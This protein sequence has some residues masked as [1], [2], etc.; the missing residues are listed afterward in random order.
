MKK[1]LTFSVLALF[2]GALGLTSCG[3]DNTTDDGALPAP[4]N[5]KAEN[6]TDVSATLSWDAVEGA[7][8]YNV[9]I[10]NKTYP[11]ASGTTIPATGLTAETAYEWKVVAVNAAGGT[12]AEAKATFTTTAPL[13]K[14]PAPTALAVTEGSIT[15]TGATFTWTGAEGATG[16]NIR[17]NGGTPTAVTGVTYTA[18]TLMGGT[19]YTWDVQSTGGAD[20]APSDWVAGTAFTTTSAPLDSQSFFAARGM[21]L[22]KESSSGLEAFLIEFDNLNEDNTAGSILTLLLFL[23]SSALGEDNAFVDLP[24]TTYN[25]VGLEGLAQNT[26]TDGTISLGEY[27]TLF[28]VAEN[29]GVGRYLPIGGTMTVSGDHTGYAISFDMVMTTEESQGATRL[30]FEGEFVGA[31]EIA[32]PNGPKSTFEEGDDI[33]SINLQPVT[34]IKSGPDGFPD[35]DAYLSNAI[36]STIVL[37]PSPQG[38]QISGTGW[39]VGTIQFHAPVNSGNTIPNGTY[40]IADSN[41]SGDILAGYVRPDTGALAGI[42]VRYF[43]GETVLMAPIVSGTVETTYSAGSYT[44][45]F[46]GTDDVGNVFTG[47][48][49]GGAA[50]G[51]APIATNSIARNSSA[52]KTWVYSPSFDRAYDSFN[53]SK[54]NISSTL[55][56]K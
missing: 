2:V 1:L 20:V 6:I 15:A 33:G 45:E 14:L 24:E 34:Y 28:Q 40:D 16:Y 43:E 3:P 23:N 26:I 39:F 21:H 55:R 22:G 31:L 7:A 41:S 19:E 51:R 53:L 13:P 5:L 56:L 11:V 10:N 49:V 36:S 48:F 47:T 52:V 27:G 12:S 18:T 4:K 42:W 37:T 35:V 25:V 9:N 44:M 30:D 29:G 32:N 17:F 38:N 46:E 8:S 54:A 50:A